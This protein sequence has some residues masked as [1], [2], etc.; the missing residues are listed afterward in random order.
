MTTVGEFMTTHVV[1]MDGSDTLAAAAREMRDAA[2]GDVIITDGEEVTGIVTD[3]DIAVRAVAEQMD[4][5]SIVL[6][7]IK[8]H[9][10]ITVSQHDDAVAAGDLM[11]TY[12]VRRLPVMEDGRLVGV[13]S[14]GDLAVEREPDS[15]LADI[16]AEDPNN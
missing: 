16:S 4:P 12:A 14:L 2:I 5:Q 3:R 6:D 1:C 9:D 13:I 11:R 8:T 15:V 10:L 7:Q